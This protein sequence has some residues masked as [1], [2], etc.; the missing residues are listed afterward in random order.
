MAGDALIQKGYF[1]SDTGGCM[2]AVKQFVTGYL[3]G[4][5]AECEEN[6]TN[7]ETGETARVYP[8]PMQAEHPCPKH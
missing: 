7:S 1:P 2:Q 3:R 6:L 4:Y 5:R 8:L